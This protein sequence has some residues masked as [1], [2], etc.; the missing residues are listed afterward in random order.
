LPR[1]LVQLSP[2]RAPPT[3]FRDCG[4]PGSSSLRSPSI[5]QRHQPCWRTLSL[6][7]R[8]GSA[9]TC[10]TT[11]R[12]RVAYLAD[13]M[14]LSPPAIGELRLGS[15]M[16][17]MGKRDK[18]RASD[19]ARNDVAGKRG[20]GPRGSPSGP[21]NPLH[22][23]KACDDSPHGKASCSKLPPTTSM[24]DWFAK[25]VPLVL[26][27]CGAGACGGG[28]SPGGSTSFPVEKL[29]AFT[30]DSGQQH[31]D[32]R[33]SPQQPPARGIVDMQ[34]TITDATSGAPQS[35]LELRVVPWMPAMG[36]G[37][38]VTP[39]VFE[40]APGIYDLQ[41]LVLFMPGTWQIRTEWDGPAVTHV[42]PTLDI[43]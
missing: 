31:V 20:L 2:D 5:R 24:K 10:R 33:T 39:T 22:V 37:T 36:H 16:Q 8:A 23:C 17:S 15:L 7:K 30:S 3:V 26:V 9:T 18:A 35:G 12:T 43:R 34:L 29:F 38:S 11:T 40:S 21:V 41:N 1:S 27:A 19:V 28:A 13:V 6:A 42:T 25:L 14:S 4:D 32:V